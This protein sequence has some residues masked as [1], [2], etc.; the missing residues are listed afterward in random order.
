MIWYAIIRKTQNKIHFQE[1]EFIQWLRNII[2]IT[3]YLFVCSFAISFYYLIENN[4][5]TTTEIYKNKKIKFY[6]DLRKSFKTEIVYL[7]VHIYVYLYLQL[8]N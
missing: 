7:Y 3:R 6:S 8:Y 1:N 4:K 2:R 5:S